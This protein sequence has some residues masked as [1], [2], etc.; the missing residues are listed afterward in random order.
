MSASI[1]DAKGKVKKCYQKNKI[2][3]FAE[4]S[5][6]KLINNSGEEDVIANGNRR[7]QKD[8]I[9]ADMKRAL[10]LQNA[11]IGE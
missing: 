11:M 3:Y 7:N 6:G 2:E 10:H 4:E 9:I 5:T 1:E 8:I